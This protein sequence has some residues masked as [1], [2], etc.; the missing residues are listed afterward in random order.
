M[1]SFF[2]NQSYLVGVGSY[3][4]LL[5][6][7]AL[8]EAAPDVPLFLA[9][10]KGLPGSAEFRLGGWGLGPIGD[11]GG[12]VRI[13]F[14]AQKAPGGA[15]APDPVKSF[16]EEVAAHPAEGYI[17]AGQFNPETI[18]GLIGVSDK[19]VAVVGQWRAE[20]TTLPQRSGDKWLLFL[21][22]RGRRSC[23]FRLSRHQKKWVALPTIAYLGADVPA[24]A[25]VQKEAALALDEAAKA[26]GE[27]LAKGAKPPIEGKAYLGSQA[28]QKCHPE[29][30]K[31]WSA[32]AIFGHK[33]PRHRSSGAEPGLPRLPRD[34]H[35]R[36]WRLSAGEGRSVRY[37]MRDVPRAR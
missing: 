32:S 36:A 13:V 30:F 25:S 14:L 34:G 8:K 20:V 26:N 29:A 18:S 4:L 17:V 28:C 35:G 24:D 5:G 21:G 31:K 37:P 11:T 6:L 10:E 1:G 2:K 3:D 22:D 19:I 16:R 27:A 9:G 15:P 7:D 23:E 12:R 33:G